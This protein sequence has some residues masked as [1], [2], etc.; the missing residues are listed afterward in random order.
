MKHVLAY[1][2]I[3]RNT[4]LL[5]I[6]FIYKHTHSK[7]RIGCKIAKYVQKWRRGNEHILDTVETRSCVYVWSTNNIVRIIF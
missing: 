7:D 3:L 5:L 6:I 4:Y 1:I 2:F